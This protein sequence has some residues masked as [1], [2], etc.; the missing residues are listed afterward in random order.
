M[1]ST[2]DSSISKSTSTESLQT[3]Y[4]DD[5]RDSYSSVELEE[6]IADGIMDSLDRTF[7]PTLAAAGRTTE[8]LPS[9]ILAADDISSAQATA[10]VKN[11]ILASRALRRVGKGEANS[12]VYTLRRNAQSLGSYDSKAD[13]ARAF[14]SIKPP[15]MGNPE[16]EYVNQIPAEKHS[17]YALARLEEAYGALVQDK[18][19]EY[20]RVQE[21]EKCLMQLRECV[22]SW[23]KDW[24]QKRDEKKSAVP[25]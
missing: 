19:E 6:S 1:S 22:R 17:D 11:L 18:M 20:Q 12:C 7:V 4:D 14:K 5:R 21:I 2:M 9:S 16:P 25:G 24:K 23:K 3:V 10:I 15:E 13:F 8:P